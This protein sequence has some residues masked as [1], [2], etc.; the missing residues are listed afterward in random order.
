MSLVSSLVEHC[1]A[2]A[3]AKLV[4]TNLSLNVMCVRDRRLGLA[5]HLPSFPLYKCC[6]WVLYQMDMCAGY[7]RSILT[8]L[9]IFIYSGLRSTFY[10]LHAYMCASSI[11]SVF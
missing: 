10:L 5:S 8:R 3:P 7:C 1:C 9:G 6:L 4:S 11:Q 2:S